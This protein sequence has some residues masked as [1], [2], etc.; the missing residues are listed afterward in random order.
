MLFFSLPSGTGREVELD[1]WEAE[2]NPER[3]KGVF[4]NIICGG[5]ITN[6][7]QCTGTKV[8]EEGKAAVTR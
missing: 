7:Q 1:V 5:F 3:K 2:S 8:R 4:V 6:P